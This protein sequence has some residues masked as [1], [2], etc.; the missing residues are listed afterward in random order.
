[1]IFFTSVVLFTQ[2]LVLSLNLPSHQ[3]TSSRSRKQLGHGRVHD[4]NHGVHGNER[5]AI[6]YISNNGTN[7]FGAAREFK[8]SSSEWN[9]VAISE[10]L[11]KQRVVWQFNPAARPI[12]WYMRPICEKLQKV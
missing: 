1:M 3:G 11:A 5:S 12:W 4:G 6:A 8:E 7:F 2:T 9:P 10:S